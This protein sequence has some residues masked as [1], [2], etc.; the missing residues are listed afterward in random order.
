MRCHKLG[1]GRFASI[2]ALAIVSLAAALPALAGDRAPPSPNEPWNPPQLHEYETQ[3]A[4][5]NF[6][7]KTNAVQ[8]EIDPEKI[9]N[10]PELIDIAERS[11]PETRVAWERAR[12]AA[13][14]VGLGKSL[15]YPYLAASAA[16]AYGQFFIPFPEL[17]TGPAP[18]QVSVLGGG[19]LVIDTIAGGGTLNLKW[20]LFDFGERKATVTAAREKLMMA[21]VGF[22]ATHQKIVFEVTKSFYE[23]DAAC[24]KVA[25]EES[26][27]LAAQTVAEAAQARFTNG[28]AIKPE[29]L[30]ANQQVAQAS[31][32]LTAAQ[33]AMSDAQVALVESLGILPTTKVRVAST[34]EEL[35]TE[36]LD[37][38]LDAL[39]DRALSQR[40]GLIAKLA[41]LRVA[42]ADVKKARAA[43]YPK[44]ALGANAGI[45]QLDMS[46]KDSSYFGGNEPVYGVGL[47]IDLPIFDGF[48]R[49]KK[50]RVA[51]SEVRVAESELAGSRDAAVREVWKSCTD[52]KTACHQEDSAETL[53]AAAQSAYDAAL[54][55]Y[56]QG[57]STYVDLMN[58]QRSLAAARSEMV[59]TRASIFTA[60]TA[61]AYSVGDLA[62]P[63]NT[64]QK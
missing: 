12:Q 41:A 45:A 29:V 32:E 35:P 33:G 31:F 44:V 42:R 61:L 21:N 60:R 15:Y 24:G 58:A 6:G 59:D 20:V 27:L 5:E 36:N 51:Q 30:Q 19:T 62:K 55:A 1:F 25:A 2:C 63:T 39:I 53:L 17:K 14:A 8:M 57:L 16:A 54:E 4:H 56:R 7:E 50:L 40:P 11:H 22:N 48:A 34:P 18:N 49:A 9:Y 23:F 52:F 38:S 26:S 43:Y 3:L 64:P 10:L 37:E 28:L 46:V 13:E 47:T